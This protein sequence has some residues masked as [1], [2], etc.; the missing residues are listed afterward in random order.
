M[1]LV[2]KVT[3]KNFNLE[4]ISKYGNIT[5]FRLNKYDFYK[6]YDEYTYKNIED[7]IYSKQFESKELDR[8]A[9]FLSSVYVSKK[10]TEVNK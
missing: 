9:D 10:L 6:R 7:Y 5:T 1:M 8:I 4:F 3:K 2:I